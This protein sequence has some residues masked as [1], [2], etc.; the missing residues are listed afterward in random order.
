VLIDP[1]GYQR[2]LIRTAESFQNS[3][4]PLVNAFTITSQ[5]SNFTLIKTYAANLS[6]GDTLN[7]NGVTWTFVTGAP[8]GNQVQIGASLSATLTAAVTAFKAS[9]LTAMKV[10]TV[11]GSTATTLTFAYAPAA[12][13]ANG[14]TLG[15]NGSTWTFVNTLTVGNQ[16]QISPT[17]TTATIWETLGNAILAFDAAGSPWGTGVTY[18]TNNA[19]LS[20]IA[21]TLGVP[22]IYK[23]QSTFPQFDVDSPINLSTFS[24]GGFYGIRTSASAIGPMHDNIIDD[25]FI[26]SWDGVMTMSP[27]SVPRDLY[28]VTGSLGISLTTGNVVPGNVGGPWNAMDWTIIP[29]LTGVSL[30]GVSTCVVVGGFCQGDNTADFNSCQTVSNTS[31]WYTGLGMGVSNMHDTLMKNVAVAYQG[32]DQYDNY[33]SWDMTW[34]SFKAYNPLNNGLAFHPDFMQ[35]GITGINA[36]TMWNSVFNAG[37]LYSA[38]DN[39]IINDPGWTDMNGGTKPLSG[40]PQGISASG[41]FNGIPIHKNVTITNSLLITTACLGITVESHPSGTVDIENNTLIWPGKPSSGVSI[42]ST[43]PDITPH[44]SPVRTLTETIIMRNNVAHSYSVGGGVVTCPLGSNAVFSNNRIVESNA[45]GTY[46]FT[47]SAYCPDGAAPGSAVVI[48]APP[49]SIFGGGITYAGSGDPSLSFVAYPASNLLGDG[50]VLNLN[51]LA[52]GPLD[53]TGTTNALC[54]N[55]LGATRVPPPNIGAY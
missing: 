47:T 50:K 39:T 19:G 42:C 23:T 37:Q 46:H 21:T 7:V 10:F 49:S 52:A 1:K 33:S 27:S 40:G 30:N 16:I 24:L 32:D 43:S 51:P 55:V 5:Q 8:V 26:T 28:P 3:T 31:V 20:T 34:D 44:V 9:A 11:Y 41:A 13:P 54:C 22:G 2:T 35:G 18:T 17:N 4:D 48:G 15:L 25:V 53:G 36:G 14:T 29:N 38:T 6:N 45:G 12:Q